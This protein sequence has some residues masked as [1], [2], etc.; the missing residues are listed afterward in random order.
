IKAETGYNKAELWII[1]LSNF[2]S[3]RAFVDKFEKEGSRLDILIENAA[4][5]GSGEYEVTEDGWAPM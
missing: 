3:V 1:D 4:L 5:I 2:A